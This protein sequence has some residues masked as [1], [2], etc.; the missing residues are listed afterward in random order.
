MVEHAHIY[1]NIQ[2]VSCQGLFITVLSYKTESKKN[3]LLSIFRANEFF[4]IIITYEISVK[5]KHL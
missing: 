3:Q 2:V 5:G 4:T 1:L